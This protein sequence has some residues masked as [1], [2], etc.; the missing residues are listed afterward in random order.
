MHKVIIKSNK[1]TA[2]II[3]KE[4]PPLL[5]FVGAETPTPLTPPDPPLEPPTV[6]VFITVLTQILYLLG[7]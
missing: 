3:I 4:S 6:V 2:T 7:K 5:L 1:T